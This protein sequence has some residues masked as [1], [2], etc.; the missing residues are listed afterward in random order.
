MRFVDTNILLC[1]V[2]TARDE[3]DK[4]QVARSILDK[5]DLA[6]SV[7]VLQEFY[8]QSTRPS[9]QDPMTHEQA[10][11]L[12]E[13]FLRFPIQ[14]TILGLMQ[15]ALSAKERFQISY[16]DAAIIE[17]ARM[18]GCRTVISEDLNDQQSYDGVTVNNPFI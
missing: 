2:S 11:L 15:A 7:Q 12:I 4:S 3:Q 9:R 18:L 17:A 8:V 16:W 10:A 1:A 13:S 14:E 6:L 5:E